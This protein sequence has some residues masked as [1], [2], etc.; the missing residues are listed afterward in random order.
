MISREVLTASVTCVMRLYWFEAGAGGIR[1]WG[2]THWRPSNYCP[3]VVRGRSVTLDIVT[4]PE[5]TNNIAAKSPF[6]PPYRRNPSARDQ[7]FPSLPWA[8]SRGEDPLLCVCSL[9]A[10]SITNNQRR[11]SRTLLRLWLSQWHYSTQN[12]LGQ[13]VHLYQINAMLWVWGNILSGTC[14]AS[15]NA[16]S[17]WRRGGGGGFDKRTQG[18]RV[19]GGSFITVCPK[20]L[21][22][23]W[24]IWSSVVDCRWSTISYE[25]K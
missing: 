17:S 22:E 15:R 19:G 10:I 23:K 4:W 2:V 16:R 7:S 3:R 5:Q 1:G 12:F 21:T 8:G 24:H 9:S 11:V 6:F 13:K 14:A 25:M 18:L 20:C